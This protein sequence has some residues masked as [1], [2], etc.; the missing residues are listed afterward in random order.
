MRSEYDVETMRIA[1]VRAAEISAQFL[2][3]TR[4][5]IDAGCLQES[6]YSRGVLFGAV[7]EDIADGFIRGERK[8]ETYKNIKKF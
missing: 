2:S 1:E 6:G 5:L 8:T 4:M 3:R 7:L